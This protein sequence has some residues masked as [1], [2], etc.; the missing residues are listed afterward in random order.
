MMWSLVPQ[1]AFIVQSSLNMTTFLKVEILVQQF[2]LLGIIPGTNIQLSLND[3]VLGLAYSLLGFVAY[4]LYV[5]A[6]NAI[7][8]IDPDHDLPPGIRRIDLIAL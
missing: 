6:L 3:L 8:H 1:F 2:L 7:E 5:A 4:R